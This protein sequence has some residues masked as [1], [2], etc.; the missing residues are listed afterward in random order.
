MTPTPTR[1]KVGP[2]IYSVRAVPGAVLSGSDDCVGKTTPS[3]LTIALD[4]E[5]PPSQVADTLLHEVIHAI[6]V[7]LD[8]DSEVEE[9]ICLTL[10]P[11]LLGVLLDNP[12]LVDYVRSCAES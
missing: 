1:I 4:E 8:L 6:L 7:S 9:R 2:H 12:A 11:G 5:C 10:G 3:R